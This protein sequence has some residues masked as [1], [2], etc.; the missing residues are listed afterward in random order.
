MNSRSDRMKL[1]ICNFLNPT[2]ISQAESRPRGCDSTFLRRKS[3]KPGKSQS[4]PNPQ[5]LGRGSVPTEW[6]CPC[7]RR[8]RRRRPGSGVGWS[9]EAD[10]GG[11]TGRWA[12]RPTGRDWSD[13]HCGVLPSTLV[14][15]AA[16]ASLNATACQKTVMLVHTLTKALVPYTVNKTSQYIAKCKNITTI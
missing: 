2:A 9:V 10:T 15:S 6:I 3:I 14:T 5:S 13:A 12:V 1:A 4:R 11:G 16:A 8:R 7:Q